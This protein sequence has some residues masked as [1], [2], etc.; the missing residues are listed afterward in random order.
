MATLGAAAAA[1]HMSCC[2]A[3]ACFT[4]G[5]SLQQVSIPAQMR[6]TRA[7]THSSRMPRPTLLPLA[8][9]ALALL[10]TMPCSEARDS[11]RRL[12][13]APAPELLAAAPAGAAGTTACVF[14]AQLAA[15]GFSSNLPVVVLDTQGGKLEEKGKNITV[16]VCTCSGG[17]TGLG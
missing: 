16:R 14:C 1:Q 12:Q 8:A 9:L 17:K 7:S 4:F 10:L 6:S 5:Q 2:S 11:A 3:S 15:I 13:Q